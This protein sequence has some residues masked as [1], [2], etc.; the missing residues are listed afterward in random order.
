MSL[1]VQPEASLENVSKLAK[2]LGNAGF[3]IAENSVGRLR[4][5]SQTP[6]GGARII[7]ARAG[8]KEAELFSFGRTIGDAIHFGTPRH[9]PV[10]DQFTYRQRLGRAFAAEFLAPALAV[11]GMEEDGQSIDMI[12]DHFGVE[13]D[14]ISYQIENAPNWVYRAPGPH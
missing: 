11:L 5:V 10:N 2:R 13:E 7:V 4:G 14:V 12:A 1:G 3:R 6:M 9:S 8:T